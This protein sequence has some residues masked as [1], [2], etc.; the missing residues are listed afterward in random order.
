MKSQAVKRRGFKSVVT[1]IICSTLLFSS[2]PFLSGISAVAP[3]DKTLEAAAEQYSAY[4]AT[5]KHNKKLFEKRISSLSWYDDV[6]EIYFTPNMYWT[7]LNKRY[8]PYMLLNGRSS[9]TFDFGII[10]PQNPN[11]YLPDKYAKYN[12]GKRGRIYLSKNVFVIKHNAG[13][14]IPWVSGK[15]YYYRY[16]KISDREATIKTYKSKKAYNKK[17]VYKTLHINSNDPLHLDS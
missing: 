3:Q 7:S 14:K 2:M 16:K 9:G 11:E 4:A 12:D 15:K 6:R 8:V 10:N 5:P 17:K 13:K 1:V